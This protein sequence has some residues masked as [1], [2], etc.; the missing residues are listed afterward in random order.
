MNFLKLRPLSGAIYGWLKGWDEGVDVLYI[1]LYIDAMPARFPLPP[2]GGALKSWPM[3]VDP[4]PAQPGTF[5][6]HTQQPRHL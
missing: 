5:K 3:M 6:D 2:L 4:S 1:Y